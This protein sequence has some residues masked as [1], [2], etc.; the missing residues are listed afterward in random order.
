M[1]HQ[2]FYHLLIRGRKFIL[3]EFGRLYPFHI[4]PFKAL[5]DAPDM[6]AFKY[7]QGHDLFLIFMM[8]G[9]KGPLGL[10][11]NIQFLFYLPFQAFLQCFMRFLLSSGELP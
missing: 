2:E 7:M 9:Y 6:H 8:N 4:L 11:I 1:R 3:H 10:Y 5:G